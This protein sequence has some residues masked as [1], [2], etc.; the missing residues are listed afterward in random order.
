MKLS[1]KRCSL[2]IFSVLIMSCL[3]VHLSAFAGEQWRQAIGPWK[4]NFPRDHGSHPEF[5]TEWWYFTGNLKDGLNKRFGYQL[6]FFRQG[7]YWGAKDSNNPWSIRDLYLAHFALTDVSSNQF[8]YGER[9]SREGPKLAYAPQDRMDVRLLNW[10]AKMDGNQIKIEARHQTMALS[11]RLLPKKPLS[12]MER[13]DS[14]K[15]GQRRARPLTTTP[16]RIWQQR[17]Q[18]KHRLLNPPF[19]SR[20]QAGSIMS[21]ARIN[22]PLIRWAGTGSAS[23][24]LMDRS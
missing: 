20:G 3:F 11:L 14:V 7:V 1:L 23:V 10:Y 6:T 12:F 13:T 21:L 8:W 19:L 2:V 15:K 5:R 4:W 18:S 9:I 24:S 17:D 22:S 16:I